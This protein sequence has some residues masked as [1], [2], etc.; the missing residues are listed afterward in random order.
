MIAIRNYALIVAGGKGVR[1][2]CEQP[3]QFLH[4]GGRPLLA[5]AVEAFLRF[6]ADMQIILVLPE[7]YLSFEK[8]IR[9]L[10]PENKD[11]I[12][13][14]KGGGTRFH[15]VRN[16]LLAVNHPGI[17]FVH[18]GVRPFIS[19]DILTRCFD[20]AI[21]AGS[22]I[23]AIPVSDSIRQWDGEQYIGIDR[24]R[25]RAVQTPQTFQSNLL[26]TAYKQPFREQFTDEAGV[27]EAAGM[28]ICLVQGD[29]SNIKITTP[30][31]L[32]W[33]EAYLKKP[34]RGT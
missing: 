31:D 33:A 20:K 26:L 10:F 17:I 1:M 6:D 13:T 12:I 7:S 2:G 23:P 21:E 9:G 25:L 4:L 28:Q 24:A 3:K 14:V 15:S 18:D 19:R 22:A 29:R 34:E 16:G 30:E 8:E 32:A 5:Y 27:M 11:Q